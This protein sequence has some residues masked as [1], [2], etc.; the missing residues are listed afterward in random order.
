MH[1]PIVNPLT[2]VIG[3]EVTNIN[4]ANPLSEAQQHNVLDAFHRHQVLF[5]PEQ[6]LT[7]ACLVRFA[8]YFGKVGIYPFAKPLPSQPEVIAIIKEPE[9]R[10]VFGGIWHTDSTYLKTPSL[11]SVLYAIEVP[12]VG[13][14]TLFANMT[15]AYD[16]LDAATQRQL[17]G[18]RAIHSS[19]KNQATLRADHLRSGTMKENDSPGKEASHPVLRTHPQTGKLSLYVSPAHT[20]RFDGQTI[21]QSAPL[22]Q[23]LFAHALNDDFKCRFRW[24]K[25]TLA[26]W[27]NRC[28]LHYPV[29]DYHGQRREM[30]RVTVEGDVPE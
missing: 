21:E 5:F 10:T 29:N 24:T 1:L 8:S 25:G 17:I 27:D 6:K 14:D 13:G 20:I 12:G 30:H 2:P 26:I 22:L 15:A 4:L 16:H 23:R 19:A 3:A 18:L 7:P 28:C 11:A 9:Q